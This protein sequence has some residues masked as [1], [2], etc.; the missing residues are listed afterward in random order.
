MGKIN[1]KIVFGLSLISIGV[2][3]Q[4][5]WLVICFSSVF[6]GLILLFFAPQ[7]LFFPFNFFFSLS[8]KTIGKEF[9]SNSN[10][11]RYS[12]KYYKNYDYNDNYKKYSY[13]KEPEN[14]N[15]YY[16]ILESDPTDSF[17]TIKKNYRKLIKKYHY[18]T[19]ISKGLSDNELKE[20]QEKTKKI[21]EAYSKIKEIYK[22][23]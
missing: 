14:T 10:F 23:R 7:I 5:I 6:I 3:L 4:V 9:K 19:N 20:I 17:E 15:N 2:L 11:K 18:D 8:M 21:N 22:K 1:Y 13:T 16:K 12:Y